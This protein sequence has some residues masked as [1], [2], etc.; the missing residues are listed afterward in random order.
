MLT[1]A[2]ERDGGTVRVT[3]G[4]KGQTVSIPMADASRLVG[5]LGLPFS[6]ADLS[7]AATEGGDDTLT[8]DLTLISIITAFEVPVIFPLGETQTPADAF[9]AYALDP[10]NYASL[11]GTI[12]GVVGQASVNGGAFSPTLTADLVVGDTVAARVIVTDSAANEETWNL[13]TVTVSVAPITPVPP[14]LTLTGTL[15]GRTYTIVGSAT[16]TPTPTFG[17]IAFTANGVS[18]PITPVIAFGVYTWT[19]VAPSSVSPTELA[20]SVTV[21]NVAGADTKS[22]SAIVTE[23]FFSDPGDNTRILNYTALTP[24]TFG[25][26]DGAFPQRTGQDITD[27]AAF[28]DGPVFLFNGLIG[29]GGTAGETPDV[30]DTVRLAAPPLLAWDFAVA[31]PVLEYQWVRSG[32]IEISGATGTELLVP[33][34]AGQELVLEIT[35]TDANGSRTARTNVLT[36]SGAA[37]L[38]VEGQVSGILTSGTVSATVSGILVE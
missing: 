29:V 22:V 15:V 12:T 27:P 10:G 23:I 5:A 18:T 8:A 25:V 13:G 28:A 14:V 19:Y 9:P 1:L 32:T 20:A 3:V 36:V 31:E 26:T 34:I 30:G 7:I 24:I 37:T 35:A 11:A 4:P 21:S 17:T 38:S 2:F 6:L 16:G 33:S